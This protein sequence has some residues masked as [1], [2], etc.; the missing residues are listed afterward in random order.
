MRKEY[1]APEIVVEKF[2]VDVMV[3]TSGQLNQED[4]IS[5]GSLEEF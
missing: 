5:L 3:T 1:E 2:T 4:S